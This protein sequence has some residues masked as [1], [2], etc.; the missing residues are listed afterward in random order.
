MQPTTSLAAI[1]AGWWS[2]LDDGSIRRV[3]AEFVEGTYLCWREV[4]SPEQGSV[5][6]RVHPNS[7]ESSAPPSPPD[8][9]G[10]APVAS[11]AIQT[12]DLFEAFSFLGADTSARSA[13]LEAN[14]D[15]TMA[16]FMD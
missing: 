14:A 2:R 6:A 15:L 4:T 8:Q 9:S 5:R 13:L 10:V 3:K 7:P 16:D 1:R 12:P 11:E